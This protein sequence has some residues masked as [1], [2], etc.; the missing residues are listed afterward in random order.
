[1]TR[2]KICGI[3]NVEDALAA[4]ECGADAIGFIFASSPRRVDACAAKR[5]SDKLP[6]F[7]TR[8][9][10]FTDANPGLLQVAEVCGLDVIQLHGEQSED[11]AK[12]IQA[13]RRIIRVVRVKDKKSLTQ[14]KGYPS[15]D[16]YLLDTY[17]KD[18]RGG[19]G[20]TFDWEIAVKAKEFG[21]PLILSGGL[22]P[23]NVAEAVKLVRP[24]AVDVSSGVESS[25]GKKDLI[26]M[27]ELIENVRKAD[28]TA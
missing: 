21:K 28:S 16:A 6:P 25:P 4:V 11:F 14:L 23:E 15:A 17:S 27:K 3:T 2:V 1:M 18:A 5:I 19:T 9:G 24:Y 13:S 8:V 26:K 10:V 7:I 12:S 20:K 22:N